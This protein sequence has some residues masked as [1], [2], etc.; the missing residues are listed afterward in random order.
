[1]KNQVHLVYQIPY[2]DFPILDNLCFNIFRIHVLN[3]VK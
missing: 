2:H 3:Y 1:M